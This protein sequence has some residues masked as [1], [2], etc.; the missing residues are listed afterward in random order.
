MYVCMYYV[1]VYVHVRVRVC[2]GAWEY[3]KTMSDPPGASVM[4]QA[5][6]SGIC[7]QKESRS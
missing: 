7:T 1:C 2:D 6:V 4:L 5:E 3:Q